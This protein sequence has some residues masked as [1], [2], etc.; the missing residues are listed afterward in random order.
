MGRSDDLTGGGLIRSAGG[1][2]AVKELQKSKVHVK[3]DE[4]ILGDGT[5]LAGFLAFK[6]ELL[7]EAEQHLVTAY[8]NYRKLGTCFSKYG[9][10]A[11]MS[12][13]IT[14]EVPA[15]VGPN[16]RGILLALVEIYQRQE[17]WKNALDCLN[18]L[19]KLEPDDVVVKLSVAE[20]LMEAHSDDRNVFRRVV[21]LAEGVENESEI[22]AALLLYKAKALRKLHVNEAARDVLTRAL[23]RKKGRSDELLPALRY[24]RALVYEDLGQHK[25]ARSEFE[26][27]YAEAADYED[28]EERLSLI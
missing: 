25:R 21:R 12:L 20:I 14:D 26:K 9:I 16:V 3:S 23:R 15:H 2:A 4:R 19:R 7:E 27:L 10:S 13:P 17:K 1:W 22:H 18:K 5:Y 11:T 6:K 8:K 24:E 28:L